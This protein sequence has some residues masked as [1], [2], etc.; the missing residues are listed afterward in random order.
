MQDIGFFLLLAT[1]HGELRG[2]IF[3]GHV[4]ISKCLKLKHLP[5]R[6]RVPFPVSTPSPYLPLNSGSKFPV[7]CKRDL[8]IKWDKPVANP[9]L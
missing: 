3:P 1:R 8:K 9:P 5:L 4:Y 7:V 6:H 2:S